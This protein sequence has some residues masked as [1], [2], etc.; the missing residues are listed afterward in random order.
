M[1]RTS[2]LPGPAHGVRADTD[3]AV[4]HPP[5]FYF[6]S[7]PRARLSRPACQSRS[8]HATRPQGSCSAT[9]SVDLC[10]HHYCVCIITVCPTS[11]CASS[12]CASSLCVSS[13]LCVRVRVS[14]KEPKP[15]S[16]YTEGA[17]LPAARAASMSISLF[18]PSIMVCTS[19]T[20]DLPRR[21]WKENDKQKKE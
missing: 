13:L 11:L 17:G 12:P 5:S 9:Q 21:S 18:T 2:H 1:A 7:V 8:V 3:A 20:S 14:R 4:D 10:V 19:C 6:H 15:K 16:G